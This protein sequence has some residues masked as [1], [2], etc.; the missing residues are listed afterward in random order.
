MPDFVRGTQYFFV[1]VAGTSVLVVMGV[2]TLRAFSIA[3]GGN[4]AAVWDEEG[5]DESDGVEEEREED[6]DSV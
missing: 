6:P 5:S 3:A 1:A 4:G 2:F